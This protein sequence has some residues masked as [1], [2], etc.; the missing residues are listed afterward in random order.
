MS[1]SALSS[2][3]KFE[4]MNQLATIGAALVEVVPV[5]LTKALP[6]EVPELSCGTMVFEVSGPLPL[7]R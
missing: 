5:S 7:M 3:P 1:V 2:A 6:S 4:G